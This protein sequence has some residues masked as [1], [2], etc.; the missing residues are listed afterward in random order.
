MWPSHL[1]LQPRSMFDT[2][3]F[4]ALSTFLLDITRP[5]VIP[6]FVALS[7]MSHEQMS[8]L[9]VTCIPNSLIFHMENWQHKQPCSKNVLNSFIRIF[10]V[11]ALSVGLWIFFGQTRRE[12]R[13]STQ[14]YPEGYFSDM[15]RHEQS[16]EMKY[17]TTE[18]H[19]SHFEQVWK[20][21]SSVLS[22]VLSDEDNSTASA[23]K[24]VQHQEL[25]IIT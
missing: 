17:G 7:Q 24:H 14:W 6:H 15:C 22:R 1:M 23:D 16:E 13:T 20:V 10:F 2:V 5:F 25:P 11:R 19:R 18:S 9:G 4:A 12:A 21:I 8:H 3:M